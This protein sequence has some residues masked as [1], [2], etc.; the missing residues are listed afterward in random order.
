[1]TPGITKSIRKVLLCWRWPFLLFFIA[2]MPLRTGAAGAGLADRLVWTS[3]RGDTLG[4]GSGNAPVLSVGTHVLAASVTDAAGLTG[5][6]AV[7]VTVLPAGSGTVD[8]LV[9]TADAFTHGRAAYWNTGHLSYIRVRAHGNDAERIG[10]V[11]FDPSVL[12]GD[13]AAATLRL[14]VDELFTPGVLQVHAVQGPWTETELVYHNRPPIAAALVSRNIASQGSYVDIDVTPIVRAWQAAPDAAHGF[15]LVSGGALDLRFGSS[16][17]RDAPLLEVTTTRTR[18]LAPAVAISS[19][20]QGAVILEGSP[21]PLA[22]TATAAG[23][24]DLADWL[25]WTSS[26]GD[27]LSTGTGQ[28][29]VLSAGT[30]VLAASV[31]DAAG[32]TGAD[33]VT[34]T[35]V[36][37][38]SATVATF[39]ATGDAFTHSGAEYWNTGQLSYIRV[40]SQGDDSERIGFVDFDASVLDGEILSAELRLFVDELFTAGTLQVHAVQAPWQESEIAYGNRPPVAAEFVSRDIALPTG[41]VDIDV[42]PIVRAW[43]AAPHAAH[44]L[45]LVS[46]GTLDLRFGSRRHSKA[47]V[48]AVAT[49]KIHEVAPVVSITS[50]ANRAVFL[51]GRP[52]PLLATAESPGG[53]GAIGGADTP[54]A[55]LGSVLVSWLP[56]TENEDGTALRDLAGYRIRWGSADGGLGGSLTIDNPGL[57]AVVIGNLAP[58]T[59][60]FTMTAYNAKGV[61]SYPSKAARKVVP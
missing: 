40:R 54:G 50:P 52:V 3:N 14:Y 18:E 61:E 55:V 35:V 33:A 34:I 47:P 56:P 21:V 41:Y 32:R 37:A 9:A 11:G 13:V 16:E 31:T 39:P 36:P 57:S 17:Y 22:A 44:G 7:T 43:R 6:D 49:S 12:E 46:A 8:T 30:H 10:F 19:P 59:Y 1:M 26:R 48:L 51:E 27:T 42:T 29:T 4:T 58:G 38:D 2:M 53:L 24:F 25:I 45:A 20:R 15:A 28:A 23:G 5:T 60:E